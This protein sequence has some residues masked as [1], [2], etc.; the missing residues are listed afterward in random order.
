MPKQYHSA[1]PTT[2]KSG[3]LP[4]PSAYRRAAREQ[5]CRPG[6]YAAQFL[7]TQAQISLRDVDLGKALDR[8][9]QVRN[10]R[11][12][13]NLTQIPMPVN[14][15]AEG[16]AFEHWLAKIKS[17]RMLVLAKRKGAQSTRRED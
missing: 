4:R 12:M 16:F 6:K 2:Y 17:Y 7:T 5:R 1:M 14:D 10:I 13:S 3:K 11:D 8:P 15:A 9:G